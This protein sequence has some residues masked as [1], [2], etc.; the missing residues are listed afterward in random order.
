MAA[1]GRA[2]PGSP[3]KGPGDASSRRVGSSPRSWGNGGP[4]IGGTIGRGGEWE[5]VRH[6]RILDSRSFRGNAGEPHA[7]PGCLA[8]GLEARDVRGEGRR[9]PKERMLRQRKRSVEARRAPCAAVSP[10]TGSPGL[11]PCLLEGP[12]RPPFSGEADVE[13]CGVS[14]SGVCVVR[15]AAMPLLK[16]G[17]IGGF[18]PSARLQLPLPPTAPRTGG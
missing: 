13:R 7:G 10:A 5:Y 2:L 8:C 11:T 15:G 18:R 3:G 16:F 14:T 12:P 4:A 17:F 1:L 6:P 9:E